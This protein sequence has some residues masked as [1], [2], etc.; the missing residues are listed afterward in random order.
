MRGPSD[1]GS[2]ASAAV[3]DGVVPADLGSSSQ[4]ARPGGIPSEGPPLDQLRLLS[5]VSPQ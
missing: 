1:E 5:V 4:F 2:G 3:V